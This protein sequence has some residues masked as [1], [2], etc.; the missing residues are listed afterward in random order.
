MPL[1]AGLVLLLVPWVLFMD[2]SVETVPLL[3]ESTTLIGLAGV[4]L[5]FGVIVGDLV[6]FRTTPVATSA[7]GWLSRSERGSTEDPR[8]FRR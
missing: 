8:L 7:L 3:L 2:D 6:L 5:L 1:L 4:A